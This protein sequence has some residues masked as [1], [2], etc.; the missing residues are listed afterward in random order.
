MTQMDGNSVNDGV[1]KDRVEKR[2]NDLY[3]EQCNQVYRNTDRLFAFLLFG[4]WIAGV[5][6]ALWISPLTWAGKFSDV[7]IHIWMSIFLGGLIVAMPITLAITCPGKTISRY[8]IAIAQMLYS[9]LL[10]HLTGGRIETHFHIFGSLAFVSFYRDWRLL[11]PA[12][13]VVIADH[14]LRG[15]YF[16]ESIYGVNLVEPL[17]WIEHAFWVVFEDIFLIIICRRNCNEMRLGARRQA[18]VEVIK[19]TVELL[20]E[21]RTRDLDRASQLLNLQHAVDTELAIS[22]SFKEA[23]SRV[24]NLIVSTLFSSNE[25]FWGAYWT[26]E[27]SAPTRLVDCTDGRNDLK[28]FTAELH[29]DDRFIK[30]LDRKTPVVS[31][32]DGF[33]T[34]GLQ[35]FAF[36]SGMR[37]SLLI[38]SLNDNLVVG[39][40]VFFSENPLGLDEKLSDVLCDIASQLAQFRIKKE[41]DRERDLLSAMVAN[42][43]SAIITNDSGGLITGWNKGAETLFGYSASEAKGNKNSFLIPHERHEELKALENRLLSG[44]TIDGYEMK[45]LT[46]AEKVI[47]VL[48]FSAPAFDE[49]GNFAGSFVTFHD[50]TQRKDAEKRVDEFYSTVSHELRTPLTS[51]RG[52]LGLMAG[53]KAGDLSDRASKLV[54]VARIEAD[55]LIRL[56]NDI[57][58]IRKIEAGMLELKLQRCSVS[59]L[60]NST[61]ETFQGLCN[62][63]GIT[64]KTDCV[65]DQKVY[66]DRDRIIQVLTN[67]ISNAI[68][69]SNR[70]ATVLVS[71]LTTESEGLRISVKDDGPG[72]PEDQRH[73]LFGKFQQLDQSDS[74]PKG[75][76]GLGLAIC[77]AIISQHHGSINVASEP[78]LGSTF[79]FELPVG[80]SGLYSPET[81]NLMLETRELPFTAL[82]VDDDANLAVIMAEVLAEQGFALEV[83]PTIGAAEE[84]LKRQLPQVIILDVNLPDGSGLSLMESLR[85]SALTNNIP[86]IMLTGKGADPLYSRMPLLIDWLVKPFDESRLQLALKQALRLGKT[87]KATALVVEDDLPTRQLIVEQM[88]SMGM[89]CLEAGDGLTA[90]EIARTHRPDLIILDIGL[91]A[92]DGFEVVEILRRDTSRPLALIVYS[93]QDISFDEREKLTLG[94]SRYLT[95][96]K[97]SEA[98][99]CKT[100]A[101]LLNGLLRS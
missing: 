7:H 53:G 100:V 30:Q 78:G 66:C 21:Q 76:T 50:F 84:I 99:F 11:I 9:A 82:L 16:P 57:L 77:K 44:E 29:F 91:P 35:A 101:E 28:S 69:F 12:S 72:I 90:V 88:Q 1:L 46:K 71:T 3:A 86:V 10:I 54:S 19:D 65:I 63:T 97:T 20:V 92:C 17:R 25:R 8:T 55:R 67:L 89:R 34:D 60:I 83:A 49:T 38:P 40:F 41:M 58:D 45:C 47:D 95:K 96:S 93:N 4:Q 24:L 36:K 33:E 73:K 79:W 15:I 27:E 51:I 32:I 39:A 6:I 37:G 87:G 13:L 48:V 70:G 94:F 14:I 59:E 80:E 22:T 26:T 68:K 98:E 56:I 18:E 52:A 43:A 74:R 75:G 64:L 23:S 5:V 62:E 2:S 42:S 81:S 31:E 61:I 85:A